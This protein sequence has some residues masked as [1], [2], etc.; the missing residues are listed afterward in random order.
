V[1]GT[2]ALIAL[3]AI[4]TFFVRRANAHKKATSQAYS[5]PGVASA[6]VSEV[7]G[8]TAVPPTYNAGYVGEK[9]HQAAPVGA[10]LGGLRGGPYDGSAPAEMLQPPSELEEARRSKAYPGVTHVMGTEAYGAPS[11]T[12]APE[13]RG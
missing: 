8:F 6:P 2:L 9:Y 5:H 12:Y 1:I 13:K 4:L 7:H 3:L 10:G 11:S